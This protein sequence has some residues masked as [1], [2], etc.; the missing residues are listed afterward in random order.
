[1]DINLQAKK[2]EEKIVN[3]ESRWKSSM[4]LL[5]YMPWSLLPLIISY[6]YK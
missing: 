3:I 5:H 2:R 4:V 1:M 6:T